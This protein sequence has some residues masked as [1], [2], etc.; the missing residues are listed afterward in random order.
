[1]PRMLHDSSLFLKA[2]A[3]CHFSRGW[4][5]HLEIQDQIYGLACFLQSSRLL[6]VEST[7]DTSLK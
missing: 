2:L 7:A 1:M 4:T 3:G 6:L 5:I